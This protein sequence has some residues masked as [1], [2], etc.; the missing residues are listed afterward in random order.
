MKVITV[1]RDGE[2]IQVAVARQY[3]TDAWLKFCKRN[4]MKVAPDAS[5]SIS[6]HLRV[7]ETKGMSEQDLQKA[8]ING[9]IVYDQVDSNILQVVPPML[10]ES[11][12]YAFELATKFVEKNYKKP[13]YA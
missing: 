8:L 13:M 5:H 11:L 10:K 6:I 2:F 7:K 3:H 12:Q 9:T 1:F 4:K